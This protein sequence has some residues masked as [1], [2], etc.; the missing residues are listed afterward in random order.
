MVI[1]TK[2]SFTTLYIGLVF[3]AN[4][5]RQILQ[6]DLFSSLPRP[7]S[8]DLLVLEFP[9]TS[10]RILDLQSENILRAV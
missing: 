5:S 7:T 2:I 1:S 9:P 3:Q 6:A 4:K 10:T 8:D